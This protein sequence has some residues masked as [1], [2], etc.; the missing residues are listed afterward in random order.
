MSNA[1]IG[2]LLG[3]GSFCTMKLRSGENSGS[4]GGGEYTSAL[5]KVPLLSGN[6]DR[7]MTV[8]LQSTFSTPLDGSKKG[9]IRTGCGVYSYA[10][11]INFELSDELSGIL[12]GEFGFFD[13]RS[14]LDITLCDGEGQI[15]IPGAVWNSF[16]LAGEVGNIIQCSISFQS[17]NGYRHEIAV[18]PPGTEAD[19]S[20][21]PELEPYWK[22]GGEGLQGFQLSI[23]RAVTP[24][25]LNEIDW[26][27]PSYLRVGHMDASF[28]VTCW[29]KWFE[30]NSII[31]GKRLL[32]FNSSSFH[33]S[34]GYQFAGI[35]GEGMKTYTNNAASL[36]GDKELFSLADVP[37]EII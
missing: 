2:F 6:Y 37:G 15:E 30:H 11:A 17:C 23:S 8:P 1:N 27:G 26:I 7:N 16:T 12:F 25:Y 34:R 3:Y 22:Y 31:L 5:L 24:T 10:G 4:T 13:R 21:L 19:Y 28:S 36:G 9:K 32:T 14:F 33:G 20:Q 35:N 29:E 18:A